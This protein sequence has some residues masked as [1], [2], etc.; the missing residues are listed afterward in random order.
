MPETVVFEGFIKDYS[1]RAYLTPKDVS[2]EVLPAYDL[3]NF[4][5]NVASTSGLIQ[6]PSGEGAI[7]YSKWVSP[8]RSRSFPFERMYNTLNAPKIVTIIPILKDEGADGE[9][10]RIG[11]MT[12]SWMNLLNIYIVLGYYASAEKSKKPGQQSRQKLSEQMFDA[13]FVHSQIQEI[14]EFKQSALHWNKYLFETRF[15]K[16][17]RTAVNAYAE[18]SKRTGVRVHSQAKLLADIS[19]VER[20]FSQFMNLSLRRSEMAR[21]REVRTTHRREYLSDGLKGKFF[22][23]N[24]LEGIY[25]LTA[26]E[27]FLKGSTYLIQ[28]SKNSSNGSL[29][30]LSGI[31]DGL[32]KLILFAKM[33]SLSVGGKQVS[34]TTRLKLT[35]KRIKGTLRMPC[36]DDEIERFISRN[37]SNLTATQ[38]KIVRLL[39]VECTRNSNLNVEIASNQ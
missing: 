5:I 12:F 14:I 38:Q 39:N 27:V 24:Y 28:E 11:Y 23:K 21:E 22:I 29:P 4:D 2:G 16:T 33:E 19:E 26:D 32:F 15:T 7:G 30:T 8:K 17:F 9:P 1:Y 35:G 31:R 25:Y 20:D 34:F 3:M 13:A 37:A 36:T 10:D 18:I 6:V